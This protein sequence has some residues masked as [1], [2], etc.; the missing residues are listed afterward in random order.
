MRLS[1]VLPAQN[2]AGNVAE[3]LHALEPV[4]EPLDGD[5]EAIFV[6]DGSTDGTWEVLR[7]LASDDRH[8]RAV[9]LSRNFGH[10][11]A[12]SAGLSLAEG[13]AVITMDSDLQ[14]PPSVIPQL[15]AR[16]AEGYDVVYAVRSSVDTENRFKVWSS[17]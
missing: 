3:I 12:L 16:G 11:T 9:R 1:V 15:L 10:Q 5:W 8:V 6:D 4:L 7:D 14:H 13:D 2:Q 17:E